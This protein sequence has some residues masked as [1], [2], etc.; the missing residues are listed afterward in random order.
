[1]SVISASSRAAGKVV[2]GLGEGMVNARG[3]RGVTPRRGL[4]LSSGVV[5]W[6]MMLM[7]NSAY[8]LSNSMHIDGLGLDSLSYS[9]SLSQYVYM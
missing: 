3:R 7:P 5:S 1:M 2:L 4:S 8:L 6:G 9:L